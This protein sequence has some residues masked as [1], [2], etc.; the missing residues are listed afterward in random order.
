M[1]AIDNYSDF[2]E[3]RSAGVIVVLAEEKERRERRTALSLSLA[4]ELLTN[5]FPCANVHIHTH[6]DTVRGAR[7]V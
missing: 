7:T 6:T 5:M 3:E 2:V 1:Q 4:T